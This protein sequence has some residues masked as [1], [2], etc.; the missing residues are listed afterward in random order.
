MPLYEA[1]FSGVT[2][3]WLGSGDTESR[4]CKGSAAQLLFLKPT[5]CSGEQQSAELMR[6]S[7]QY[8]AGTH[9]EVRSCFMMILYPTGNG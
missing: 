1:C 7:Q 3:Q 8:G 6:S 2:Q 9:D 4:T 5:I